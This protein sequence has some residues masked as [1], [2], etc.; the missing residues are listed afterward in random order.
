MRFASKLEFQENNFPTVCLYKMSRKFVVCGTIESI[1]R[2]SNS[3]TAAFLKEQKVKQIIIIPTKLLKTKANV[4][5]PHAGLLPVSFSVATASASLSLLSIPISVWSM[6]TAFM[7]NTCAK[8]FD[9]SL[10]RVWILFFSESQKIP[11]IRTQRRNAALVLLHFFTDG[12][13]E[14]K[15]IQTD[16][17]SQ[18]PL[19]IMYCNFFY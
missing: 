5:W 2:G 11:V 8:R 13:W 18:F 3:S 6:R 4:W 7:W 12:A 19:L 17:G 16:L 1:W 14:P 9:L 10:K 15:H